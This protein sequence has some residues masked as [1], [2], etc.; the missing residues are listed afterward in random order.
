MP[1]EVTVAQ[2]AIFGPF[3]AMA[4][5]TLAVWVLLYVR[6]IRYMVS[7]GIAPQKLATPEKIIA[8]LPDSVNSPA[9]NFKNLF[10]LP[11]LFYAMALYLYVT[12]SVDFIYVTAAWIFV[13]FRALHSL[14]HCTT[15][16]VMTRFR[17]YVLAA[18]AL[19]F[20][21]ARAVIQ[22]VV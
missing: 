19:W 13:V 4:V 12:A 22:L 6:R 21:V 17:L 20:I 18:L 16:H 15:N 5:L 2:A 9:N 10:E 3:L 8:T 7:E 14:V 11:V 1:D